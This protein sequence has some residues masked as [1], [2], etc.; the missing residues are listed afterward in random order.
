MNRSSAPATRIYAVAG[1]LFSREEIIHRYLHLVKYVAGRISLGLPPNVEVNEFF[2]LAG[3]WL[4]VPLAQQS[5]ISANY[6]HAVRYLVE[7]GVNVVAQLVARRGDPR[8]EV[9]ELARRRA[10]P[11]LRGAPRTA[12]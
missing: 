6:T 5:Y 11:P 9:A 8:G 1:Q 10:V 3:R 7:R 4:G 2:F 12:G